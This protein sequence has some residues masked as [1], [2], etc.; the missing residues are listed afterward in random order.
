MLRNDYYWT[1]FPQKLLFT[2]TRYIANQAQL[3]GWI[4]KN[5]GKVNSKE[6]ICVNLLDFHFCVRVALTKLQAWRFL[7][8]IK[9]RLQH[10]CLVKFAKFFQDNSGGCFWIRLKFFRKILRTY[11]PFNDRRCDHIETIQIICSAKHLTGFNVMETLVVKGLIEW[12][13]C[14]AS[15]ILLTA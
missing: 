3:R 14:G 6:V 4:R 12:S 2:F 8:F 10:R 13:P 9:T 1:L 15:E 11:W 5:S 7:N